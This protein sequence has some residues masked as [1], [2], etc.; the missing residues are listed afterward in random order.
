MIET[1][2]LWPTMRVEFGYNKKKKTYFHQLK[3][4]NYTL[5]QFIVKQIKNKAG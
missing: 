4:C 1:K 5:K 2:I 3:N